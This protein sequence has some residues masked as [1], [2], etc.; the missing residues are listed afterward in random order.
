MTINSARSL[1]SS[2]LNNTNMP[3]NSFT[4]EVKFDT[5]P[6]LTY[7]VPWSSGLLIQSA[8]E[9]CYNYSTGSQHPFTFE[10]Q[11]YGT[12]NT[13]FLGYMAVAIN[14]TYR[15]AGYLWYVYL[16]GVKTNNSLDA[17]PLNPGDV[18]EFKYETYSVAETEQEGSYYHTLLMAE[19]ALHN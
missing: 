9:A 7:N 10:L 8:M 14:G 18:V 11:Y 13:K 6:V 15:A 4:I 17:V 19:K 12:Y 5:D 1:Y 3:G 2:A 16:N